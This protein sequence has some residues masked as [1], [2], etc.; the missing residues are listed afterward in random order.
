MT[1]LEHLVTPEYKQVI[2]ELWTYVQRTQKT[3]QRGANCPIWDDLNIN[4]ITVFRLHP[5]D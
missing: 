1:S 2:K 5:I 4:E 3:A